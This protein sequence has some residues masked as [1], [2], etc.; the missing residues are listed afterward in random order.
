MDNAVALFRGAML[1]RRVAWAQKRPLSFA[2]HSTTSLLGCIG[3]RVV[4]LRRTRL[5]YLC[6]G[7]TDATCN[8]RD[9]GFVHRELESPASATGVLSKTPHKESAYLIYVRGE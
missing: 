1:G 9:F 8:V 4:A 2:T 5:R 7:S 3:L 6:Q